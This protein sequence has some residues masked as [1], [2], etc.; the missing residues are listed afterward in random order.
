MNPI[1]LRLFAVSLPLLLGSVSSLPG[2][3]RQSFV[4]VDAG[5]PAA[6][7]VL[8]SQPS[9]AAQ[10]AA[11]ELRSHVQKITGALLPVTSDA[12]NVSGRKI[13]IGTSRAVEALG[14]NAERF[15]PEEYLIRIEPDTLVLLGRDERSFGHGPKWTA[16]R[17]GQALQFDGVDDGLWIAESGFDDEAGTLEAWVWMPAEPQAGESTILRLDSPKPWTYHILRR[18]TKQSSLSYT[19]YDGKQGKG[20]TSQPV[21]EGWH[22]VAATHDAS[23][24]Q[25]ELFVDGRSQGTAPYLKTACRNAPLNIGGIVQMQV[26]NSKVSNPFRGKIDE[27]RVSRVVRQFKATAPPGPYEPDAQTGLLLHFDEGAGAPQD[28]SGKAILTDIPDLFEAKSTLYAVYDFLERYGDVRWYGPGEIATVCPRRPTLAVPPGE[29]RRRPAM[30]FRTIASSQLFFTTPDQP[31]S[32]QDYS[33]WRLRMRLGGLPFVASHSFYGYYD[34]FLKEHPDWFARGYKGRP[35]QL[36]YSNPK[37]VAQVI[38]D[39]RDYFDGK[40][41]HPG[42]QVL[43]NYFG[44]VPMDNGQWCKCERCQAQLDADEANNPQFNNG[45]ASGYVWGFVNQVAREVRKTHP[46]KTLT[47][48]AY[49]TYAYYPKGIHLEENIAVQLCLH[50]RNWWCP[51]MEVN[52][53]KVLQQWVSR[54]GGRRPIYLWLYYCFPGLL[55]SAWHFPVFPGFFAHQVVPQMKLYHECGVKGIFMEHHGETGHSFL[56]DQLEM[57]VTW[58]LADDPTLDGNRLID[59]FF[60][61]YYGPAAGPM[62]GLY[63]AIEETVCSPANYPESIRTSPSHQHQTE[64][65]AWRYLGTPERMARFAELMAAAKKA[66]GSGI[67]ARRVAL[68]EEGIWKPMQAG[69]AQCASKGASLKKRGK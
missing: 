5:R 21:A 58:K 24:G 52:D 34:R 17:F 61:R 35:P 63:E 38:Q 30:S 41:A 15:A 46:D 64:E 31:V 54:E 4:V 6:T 3:E 32:M 8:A 49:A 53:R 29:I 48:L 14:L 60:A 47:A 40:P 1:A 18:V 9:R 68:F 13:L 36:C 51:S 67:E 55:G 56:N 37:V 25:L 57:Y 42:A 44:L 12:S 20:I 45:K 11:S 27:V 10:L 69:A 62:K 22:H 23:K 26:G 33:L 65:L 43:G 2:A 7:I 39:A 50:T 66:A 59:E 19:V 28:A 16:G